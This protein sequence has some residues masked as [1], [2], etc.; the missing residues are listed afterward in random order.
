MILF[1]NQPNLLINN[2]YHNVFYT[3]QW[4][5]RPNNLS[6]AKYTHIATDAVG[7]KPKDETDDSI[8]KT[9]ENIRK[10]LEKHKI[11][12]K[13]SGRLLL[14]GAA[15]TPPYPATGMDFK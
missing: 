11:D 3:I 4:L 1:S 9:F 14:P 2:R 10:T 6:L 8:D 13:K 15:R 5:K 12:K 7:R